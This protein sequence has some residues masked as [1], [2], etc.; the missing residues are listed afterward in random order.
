MSDELHEQ[1][2]LGLEAEKFTRSRLG[3]WVFEQNNE[4]KDVNLTDLANVS[5][6]KFWKISQLQAEIRQRDLFEIWLNE[7]I[8]LGHQAVA[9]LEDE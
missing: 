8:A 3:K 5:P 7:A 9:E 4:Q 2:R 1:A 6:W